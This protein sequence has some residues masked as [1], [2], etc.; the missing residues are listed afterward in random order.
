MGPNNKFALSYIPK[1]S[2]AEFFKEF[3]RSRRGKGENVHSVLDTVGRWRWVLY[4]R[5]HRHSL[6]S[7]LKIRSC[8]VSTPRSRKD[9]IDI[10]QCAPRSVRW[11]V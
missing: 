9:I 10:A 6:R 11:R 7:D 4:D 8:S 1:Q 2:R 5:N 3:S